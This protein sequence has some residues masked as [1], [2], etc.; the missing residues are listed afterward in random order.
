M[1]LLYSEKV[2]SSIRYS[3]TNKVI[4]I[5]DNL[6]IDNPDWLMLVMWV[7][8]KLKAEAVNDYG[9]ATG[10]IQFTKTTAVWLGTTTPDLFAMGAINQLD[11]VEKYLS[12]LIKEKG[13]PKNAYDLYFLVHLKTGFG[14]A[15][16]YVLYA[17]PSTS[18]IGNK[19]L[20]YN[21]SKSVTVGEIK[22]F[23]NRNL[24]TNYDKANLYKK[25]FLVSTKPKDLT[26]KIVLLVLLLG[27]GYWIKFK[28][29]YPI[30]KNFVSNIIYKLKLWI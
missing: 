27:L 1:S 25:S 28:G 21:G 4:N 24:P 18:Y 13:V 17:S 11:Y 22:E 20:D 16:N 5:C 9:G 26:I 3:F 23:L 10:L 15:D 8:S 19:A 7:E 29:G 14:K 6:N 2:P 30:L 12:R